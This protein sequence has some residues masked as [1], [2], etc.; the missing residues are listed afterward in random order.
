[1]R[2]YLK[3]N[4]TR[5]HFYLRAIALA[6]LF[7]LTISFCACSDGGKDASSSEETHVLAYAGVDVAECVSLGQYKELTVVLNEGESK[8][9]A[10]WRVIYASSE[11][12]SYPEEQVEYYVSQSSARCEYYA[13]VHDVSYEEA[14]AALGYDG[15]EALIAEAKALVF[16][17]LVGIALRADAGIAL[18]D[19]EKDNFFDK[20]A[21]KYAYDWGYNLA[22][23]E[24]ELS[25]Q[26]YGS[27]LY[28]KTTEYLL[29]YN[30]FLES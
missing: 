25:E 27:M 18:T 26:V 6:A 12:F 30:D 29:K 9:E 8:A 4:G 17:D 21:E 14:L 13:S 2:T 15:E 3:W 22:Y 16:E 28:D 1:M 19:E 24:E 5:G 7:A 23:V 11:V 20:Y 10:V